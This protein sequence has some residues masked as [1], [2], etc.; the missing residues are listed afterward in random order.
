MPTTSII[1]ND[2]QEREASALI[3]Q[4]THALSSEQVLKSL[5]EGLPAEVIEGV[6]RS[7]T[8]ERKELIDS[9]E[10]YRQAQDGVPD[11]LKARAGNDVGAQLIAARVVRGWKQKDLARRLFIPD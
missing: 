4:I 11:G 6:R 10:A 7:L 8:A 9:L 2:R 1:A 5:V 3:A